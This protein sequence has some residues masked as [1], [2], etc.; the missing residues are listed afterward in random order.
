MPES[1]ADHRALAG[2]IAYALASMEGAHADHAAALALFGDMA[3]LRTGESNWVSRIYSGTG[4]DE[5]GAIGGQ[6]SGLSFGGQIK[7]LVDEL[8]DGKTR[9]AAIARD[10]DYLDRA[11][12]AKYYADAGN[13]NGGL[14]RQLVLYGEVDDPVDHRQSP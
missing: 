5:E 2:Q 1:L 7:S 11:I 4:K 10:A 8:K 12:Q 3:T 6:L 13:K 9:E 14:D